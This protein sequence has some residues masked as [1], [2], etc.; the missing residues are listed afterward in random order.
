MATGHNTLGRFRYATHANCFKQ[1]N[2]VLAK[3][4]KFRHDA[5][6][7]GQ[8]SDS[9]LTH[10]PKFTTFFFFFFKFHKLS[11]RHDS[12]P[13]ANF[14]KFAIFLLNMQMSAVDANE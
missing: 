13:A 2:F 8:W 10:I 7:G 6:R 14:R 12:R 4:N 5:Q 11:I 1:E 9:R 3:K